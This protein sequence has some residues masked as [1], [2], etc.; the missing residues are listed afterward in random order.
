MSEITEMSE[1]SSI[2]CEVHITTKG[3][4]L[5]QKPKDICDTSKHRRSVLFQE[6]KENDDVTV[7]LNKFYCNLIRKKTKTR[8]GVSHEV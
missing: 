6:P 7:Q 4:K 1:T 3:R 5:R 8:H 2:D